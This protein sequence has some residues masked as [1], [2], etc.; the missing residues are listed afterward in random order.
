MPAPILHFAELAAREAA[1]LGRIDGDLGPV[2]WHDPCQLGRGLG[3]YEAPRQVLARVLGRAPDEFD[4]SRQGA[5][6]SGAG[7]LVPVT[8]PDVARAIAEQRIADHERHGGGTIVTACASS[9]RSFERAGAK[10]VD[11]A[12]VVRRA[13]AGGA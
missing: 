8:M 5:R 3:I 12:T 4:R 1:A 6:C 13:L 7:G 11:L 9:L 10:V 2:R